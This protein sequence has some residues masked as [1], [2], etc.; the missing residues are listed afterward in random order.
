MS[1]LYVSLQELQGSIEDLPP[2][3]L[4]AVLGH[5]NGRAL[6]RAGP[7]VCKSWLSAC[8]GA[9][10]SLDVSCADTDARAEGAAAWLQRHGQELLELCYECYHEDLDG[11]ADVVFSALVQ[12]TQLQ[13]LKLEGIDL[14]SRMQSLTALQNLTS[15]SLP[16][17]SLRDA[18]FHPLASLVSL[19]MLD[20]TE[21]GVFDA[22]SE[23][24]KRCSRSLSRL[25]SLSFDSCSAVLNPSGLSELRQLQ[26]LNLSFMRDIA[27]R[28]LLVLPVLTKL[29]FAHNRVVLHADIAMALSKLQHL[30]ITESDCNGDPTAISLLV[31]LTR[32][33]AVPSSRSP[34]R[35]VLTDLGPL[36]QLRHLS[37]SSHLKPTDAAISSS[38]AIG[39]LQQVTY[40]ELAGPPLPAGALAAVFQADTAGAAAACLP[41]LQFL[42]IRAAGRGAWRARAGCIRVDEFA[43]LV[44]GCPQLRGLT[45]DDHPIEPA[46]LCCLSRLAGLTE[47]TVEGFGTGEVRGFQDCPC[48]RVLICSGCLL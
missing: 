1:K 22:A 4:V 7:T 5:L 29:T 8:K 15:L 38:S 32:L 17:C 27:L 19:R 40:L 6:L 13:S 25:S 42:Q 3:L 16:A 28:D 37:V 41:R 33:D 26:E 18:D 23:A 20:L 14:H 12:L 43:Q 35:V 11:A 34:A 9:L 45:L 46:G 44:Q 39:C 30:D 24:F 36:Q 48:F 47:L 31:S 10:R 2:N 21:N